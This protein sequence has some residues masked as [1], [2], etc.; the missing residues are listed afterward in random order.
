LPLLSDLQTP[1]QTLRERMGLG[2]LGAE[3]YAHALKFMAFQS[4][5]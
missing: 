1:R 5:S 2:S 3:L 4:A